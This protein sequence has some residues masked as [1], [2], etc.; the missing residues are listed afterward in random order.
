[1]GDTVMKGV[2]LI[3]AWALLTL[4]LAAGASADPAGCVIGGDQGPCQSVA[5]SPRD[6]QLA[7][8]WLQP[9]YPVQRSLGCVA[10]PC[11]DGGREYACTYYYTST[12]KQCST[13]CSP[14][15]QTR[16]R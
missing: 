15:A 1:M 14:E 12:V 9:F 7:D 3:A 10:T 2:K 8:F 11:T 5:A 6:T 13:C 16:R 4:G